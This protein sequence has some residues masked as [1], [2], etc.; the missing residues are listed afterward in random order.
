MPLELTS[1]SVAELI[2]G[3]GDGGMP[4]GETRAWPER[5]GAGT[6]GCTEVRPGIV[7]YVIDLAP[8]ED[9]QISAP[10]GTGYFEWGYHLRGACEGA[11]DGCPRPVDG[12]AGGSEGL[13]APPGHGGVVAFQRG[14]PV[15]TVALGAAPQAL[16]DLVPTPE[17]ARSDQ[18]FES[19]ARQTPLVETPRPMT[20]EAQLTARQIIDCPFIGRAR[21]LFLEAK[22]LELLAGELRA[23]PE[24]RGGRV[25]PDDERRVH[26]AAALL[27]SQLEEPPT[28]RGLA[29][30][31]GTNELK[32]KRGFRLVYG[33][34]VFGYL[35]HHRLEHARQLLLARQVNVTEAAALVG[36]A[37]PSRFAAAFQRQ[38][39]SRP[40]A[41]RRGH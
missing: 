1:A 38:F 8:A 7:L 35:R 4:I 13:Y 40:S 33:T 17:S 2:A 27:R 16:M 14:V 23:H 31:V 26:Q 29:R 28:L 41:V 36:Y 18:W 10:P 12:R 5:I 30:M 37:C 15:L 34:T 6:F 21:Q 20:S 11:I 19:M 25:T 39:G 9:V 32:L 3:D 24:P 22:V